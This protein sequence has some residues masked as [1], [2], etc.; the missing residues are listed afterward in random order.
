M[1]N[2]KKPSKKRLSAIQKTI[3]TIIVSLSILIIGLAISI[4]FLNP[5]A[6]VKSKISALASE[7]YENFLYENL[8]NSDQVAD[9]EKTSKN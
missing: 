1:T 5:E 3:L 8:K 2:R 7:Y 4:F 6:R 9:F